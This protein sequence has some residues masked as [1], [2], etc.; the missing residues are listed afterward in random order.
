MS[1]LDRV[2]Q[3][4]A[5]TRAELHR[6][7][8]RA[9]LNGREVEVLSW[10]ASRGR[11]ACRTVDVAVEEILV[12]AE[13]LRARCS[14]PTSN[15]TDDLADAVN[16]LHL[17]AVSDPSPEL[18]QCL[19]DSTPWSA[20]EYV[21]FQLTRVSTE[22][23]FEVS[24]RLAPVSRAWR[25][26]IYEW[27]AELRRVSVTCDC[28]ERLRLSSPGSSSVTMATMPQRPRQQQRRRASLPR[29]LTAAKLLA[30]GKRCTQLRDLELIG[31][32]GGSSA[33]AGL[34]QALRSVAAGCPHLEQMFVP[35][36]DTRE[37]CEA[38][39]AISDHVARAAAQCP[40]LAFLQLHHHAL[41]TDGLRQLASCSQLL[42]L[43][44]ALTQNARYHASLQGEDLSDPSAFEDIAR[45]CPLLE[46]LDLSG[47]CL[48]DAAVCAFARACPGLVS[49]DFSHN[50]SGMGRPRRGD[51]ALTDI[52]AYS[53]AE[54]CASKLRKVGLAGCCATAGGLLALC[55]AL[56]GTL[57]ELNLNSVDAITDDV[58]FRLVQPCPN[59]VEFDLGGTSLS[60]AGARRLLELGSGMSLHA[61]ECDGITEDST[62]RLLARFPDRLWTLHD[63]DEDDEGDTSE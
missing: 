10:L 21:S 20:Y 55:H 54:H 46:V 5:G 33:P 49:I 18:V 11:W 35:Y 45:C 61:Y 23:C 14:Q 39:F 25:E 59:L 58:A 13:N 63:V 27:R 12:R 28:P 60:E 3:P 4:A 42:E 43:D 26:R 1:E 19:L 62:R 31:A 17:Q 9:D 38:A 51:Y 53:L 29:G 6:L 15:A 36:L 44:L 57:E 24:G 56:G 2:K 40:R 16:A 52:A 22:N 32:V 48:S 30:V 34:E 8:G 47:N 37:F 41:S 7:S 50:A